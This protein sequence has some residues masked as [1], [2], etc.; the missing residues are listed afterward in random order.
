MPQVAV[1]V[2]KRSSSYSVHITVHDAAGRDHGERSIVWC[3]T[4]FV[5]TGADALPNHFLS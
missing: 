5:Q 4:P 2:E 3:A 1:T